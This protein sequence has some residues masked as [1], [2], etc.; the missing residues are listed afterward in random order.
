MDSQLEDS[1]LAQ[2]TSKPR[3]RTSDTMGMIAV[4]MAIK[5]VCRSVRLDSVH[6]IDTNAS[7]VCI[8]KF[9]KLSTAAKPQI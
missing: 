3:Q 5:L 4:F 9:G 6:L 1:F 2:P 8:K 7:R